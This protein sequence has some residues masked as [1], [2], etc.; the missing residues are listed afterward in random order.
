MQTTHKQTELTAT[1]LS[2]NELVG[3]RHN[4]AHLIWNEV[5]PILQRALEYS[6]NKYSL[7]HIKKCVEERDMQLWVTFN[8]SQ[9]ATAGISQIVNYPC[10]KRM[11]ILFLSGNSENLYNHWKTMSTWG[12]ANGCTSCEIYGRP[13]WERKLESIGFKKIHTVLKVNL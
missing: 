11:V 8:N 12:K 4:Q 10:E 2:D 1:Y 7:E 6:D 3:I 9:V 5:E 13:G